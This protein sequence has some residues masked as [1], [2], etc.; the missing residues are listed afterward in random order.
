MTDLEQLRQVKRYRS[1]R[2]KHGVCSA[3]VWREQSGGVYHCRKWPE[4]QGSCDTD[5]KLPVFQFD[6]QV[7]DELRGSQ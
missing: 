7:M 3:C 2:R 1:R 4:R 6:D 5:G